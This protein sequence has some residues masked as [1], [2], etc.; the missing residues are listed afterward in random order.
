M[1][2]ICTACMRLYEVE[3]V[4]ARCPACSAPPPP[5]PDRLRDFARRVLDCLDAQRRYFSSAKDLALL[6]HSKKLK[7]SLRAE[8]EQIVEGQA[9]LF[10]SQGG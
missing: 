1:K 8:A 9:G 4:E 2:L 3:S 10:D 6:E 5:P 7:R